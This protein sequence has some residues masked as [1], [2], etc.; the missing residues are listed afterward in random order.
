MAYEIE[1]GPSFDKLSDSIDRSISK[2]DLLDQRVRGLKNDASSV[3]IGGRTLNMPSVG[4]SGPRGPS[5]RVYDVP[6]GP[7]QRLSSAEHRLTEMRK[8]GDHDLIRDAEGKV[9]SA[10]RAVERQERHLY[11]RDNPRSKLSDLI[12]SSRIGPGGRLYPLL[13]KL[14][15]AGLTSPEELEKLGMS[16]QGAAQ[17][18]PML[19]Q[20]AKMALPMAV[21]MAGAYGAYKLADGASASITRRGSMR[22]LAGGSA[23]QI[24]Q[25]LGLGAT[26][27]EVMGLGEDLRRGSSASAYFASKGINDFGDYTD[28]KTGNYIKAMDALRDPRL[29]DVQRRRYIR[30]MPSLQDKAWMSDPELFPQEQYDRLKDSYGANMTDAELK[31]RIRAKNIFEGERLRLSNHINDIKETVGT[32]AMSLAS[33]AMEHS[34]ATIAAPIAGFMLGGPAGGV[35]A[36]VAAIGVE[37]LSRNLGNWAGGGIAKTPD[38]KRISRFPVRDNSARI[39]A[40]KSQHDEQGYAYRTSSGGH[41][42]GLGQR[43]MSGIAPGYAY[44]QLDANFTSQAINMGAFG[45]N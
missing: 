33:T 39:N 20:V 6:G 45:V 37:K 34:L 44:Q 10:R 22:D 41:S 28:N 35:A 16:A 31:D 5:S 29:S 36:G 25:A 4:E 12:A 2:V 27:Q 26:T 13:G 9:E 24:G 3:T 11:E 32:P 7:N 1:I 38:T 42:S 43:A 18:A 17:I 40:E 30:Q 14:H 21:G 23:G 15:E 19:A 8:T